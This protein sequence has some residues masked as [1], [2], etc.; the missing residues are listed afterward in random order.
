[1]HRSFVAMC[2]PH[3]SPAALMM[4]PACLQ[5]ARHLQHAINEACRGTP[6][7]TK[8]PQQDRAVRVPGQVPV[9]AVPGDP[10]EENGPVPAGTKVPVAVAEAA[11]YTSRSDPRSRFERRYGKNIKV[12]PKPSKH[13][14]CSQSSQY[15]TGKHFQVYDARGTV[16]GA[17]GS[18]DCALPGGGSQW[19]YKVYNGL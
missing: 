14:V 13:D 12:V 6:V 18:C 17:Y 9:P 3:V 16:V 1:M 7:S 19:R 4:M 2:G 15:E 8:P 5:R 10:R 11:G